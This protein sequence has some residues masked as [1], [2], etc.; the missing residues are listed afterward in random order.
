MLVDVINKSIFT[1]DKLISRT[2]LIPKR[3]QVTEEEYGTLDYWKGFQW[4]VIFLIPTMVLFIFAVFAL[5][6]F[7]NLSPL[8]IMVLAPLDF[9]LSLSGKSLRCLS[10][11]DEYIVD[12]QDALEL[13]IHAIGVA[14]VISLISAGIQ[15]SGTV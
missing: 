10:V 3:F 12:N 4:R 9:T 13:L 5:F 11:E 2:F 7:Y 15:A 14:G 8:F 1:I 6:Y